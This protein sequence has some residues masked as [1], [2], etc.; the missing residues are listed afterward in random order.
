MNAFVI[1]FVGAGVGGALRHGVNLTCARYCG[2]EFPWGT[3]IINVLGSTVMGLLAGWF[4]FKA[5]APWSVNARL[6]AMTGVLGG[7]TTFSAYSLDA[8]LLWE[9]G[10]NTASVVY[11]MASVLLAL[12][13]LVGGLSLV[14]T[15]T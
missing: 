15:L 11:V 13:G 12:L 14:R 9:R 1:V 3:L 8:V 6:F 2:L 4:A 10:S 7:F 5:A